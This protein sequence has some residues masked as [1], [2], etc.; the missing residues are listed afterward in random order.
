MKK[1]VL[2]SLTLLM[3]LLFLTACGVPQK[4]YDKLASDLAVAQAQVQSLR[5]K[6]DDSKAMI[7]LLTDFVIPSLRGETYTMTSSQGA[8]FLFE[9][10]DK[11]DN[12]RDPLLTRKFQIL[13]AAWSEETLDSFYTYLRE[14]I[15]KTLE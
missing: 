5:Q 4:D 15:L 2:L 3:T 1:I 10:A 11:V 13:V 7:E 9:W 6:I 8:N 12:I 14:A